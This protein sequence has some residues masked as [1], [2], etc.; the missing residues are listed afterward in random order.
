MGTVSHHL[1]DSREINAAVYN[2]GATEANA[3]SRRP[4]LPQFYGSIAL[5]TDDVNANYH[6]LQVNVQKRLSS[7]DGV[8]VT[9]PWDESSGERSQS[10]LGS[11]WRKIHNNWMKGDRGLSE[12]NVGQ[13]L[14]ISELLGPPRPA[15]P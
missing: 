7:D 12:V 1:Y 4:I 5:L 11:S 13:I 9:Y 2:P 10:L 6:S 3:Q 8:Q 15:W 14:A